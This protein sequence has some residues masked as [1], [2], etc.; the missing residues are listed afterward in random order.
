MCDVKFCS[1]FQDEFLSLISLK[2]A[3]GFKY[4]TDAG[5][6]KRIDT[7]FC[8]YGLSEKKIS[9]NSVTAGAESAPTKVKATIATGSAPSGYSA[10][11][12]EAS[13]IRFMYRLKD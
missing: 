11:I 10:D 1:V 8:D 7:F 13:D 3:L 9:R 12:C 2:R 6:F 5:A 4:E